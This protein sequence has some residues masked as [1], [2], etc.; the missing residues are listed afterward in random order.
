MASYLDD[1]YDFFAA[2]EELSLLYAIPQE[3]QQPTRT[4]PLPPRGSGLTMARVGFSHASGPG[5]FD[6]VIPGGARLV[7]QGAPGMER[8]FSTLLKRH[9][10]PEKGM[11]T[12]GGIDI[13]A[14]DLLELRTDVQVLDRPA[15]VE[16]SIAEYL[17]LSNPAADPAAM[18]RALT[19]VGL[20]DRIAI[21]PDGMQTVLSSTGYPLSLG[22]TMQLRLAAAILAEPHIL[23]L[24]PLF[25]MVSR[26][27]L[28]AVFDHFA[29]RPTTIVYFT[30]RPEDLVLDGF[31]WL[32]RERQ[33]IV[34][35]RAAF[36]GLRRAG[37]VEAS[38]GR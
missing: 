16:S 38:L 23:V 18:L 21:L 10:R 31:L 36:D 33:S 34:G 2:V 27:R 15:V 9:S 12:I 28:Q 24:S 11:I 25:D 30:N 32:G 13:G 17:S 37:A 29:D 7:A 5:Q 22:K 3:P 19:L 26:N 20:D 35:D 1:Y 8:V 6:L 4:V 14:L